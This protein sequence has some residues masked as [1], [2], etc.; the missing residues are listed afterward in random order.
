M[1][2]TE[3]I[4]LFFDRNEDA[5]INTKAKYGRLCASIARHILPDERD[6]EE[7][8]EDTWIRAWNAIPPQEPR[9]LSAFLSTITRNLALDKHSYNYAE[10]RN[11]GITEAFDELEDVLS[12][13]EKGFERKEETMGFS[14]FINRFLRKQS[15]DNR[16][17]FVR[18][19]WYGDSVNEIAEDLKM[20]ESKVKTS[21]FRTRNRLREAM[22]KEDIKIG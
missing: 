10:I 13:T 1:E 11:S 4:S 19:Y 3:I 6:V 7:C 12:F 17:I 8:V 14:E 20:S 15:K 22:I 16:I 18:R 5:I 9:S 2:D 21:L